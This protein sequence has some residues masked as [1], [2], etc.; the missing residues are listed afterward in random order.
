MG[1]V[2]DFEVYK[3][4]RDREVYG[5]RLGVNQFKNYLDRTTEGW[6]TKRIRMIEGEPMIVME[7]DG[8]VLFIEYDG[9]E[10]SYN[11]NM[12]ESP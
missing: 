8:H 12:I 9:F 7:K 10:I 11:K 4:R 1:N 3:H 6:L 2:I 5:V